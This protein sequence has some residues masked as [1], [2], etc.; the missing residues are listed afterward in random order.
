MEFNSWT[1]DKSQ[2]AI[3]QEQRFAQSKKR[4]YLSLNDN[5]RI[6]LA[7]KLN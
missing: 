6:Y 2:G 1:I 4:Q 3:K 5:P 7:K